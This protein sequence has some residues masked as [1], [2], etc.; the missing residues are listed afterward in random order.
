ME[1]AAAAAEERWE[2]QAPLRVG[3]AESV[4][5]LGDG[6]AKGPRYEIRVL[7]VAEKA[8]C[9][10]FIVPQGRE[11]EYI[12]GTD[13]GLAQVAASAGCGRL[14]AVSL[15][16]RTGHRFG[17]L[18]AVQGELEGIVVDL[19]PKGISGKIPFVTVGG[20]LGGREVVAR[21]VT[22]SGDTYFVEEVDE[23]AA[24]CRRLVFGSNERVVQTEVALLPAGSCKKKGRGK[25]K[26]G[27]AAKRAAAADAPPRGGG[28]R[29]DPDD[30][31][32]AY[33]AAMLAAC[34][35]ADAAGDFLLVGLG[36]GA[37][38]S[39]V[40]RYRPAARLTVR[41]LDEAVVDVATTWFGFRHGADDPRTNVLVGDDLDV[42]DA[43]DAAATFDVVAVDV[44]AKDASLGMCC[45]PKAFV[46]TDYVSKVKAK[47]NDGGAFVVNV[48]ARR[49]EDY[50]ETCAN[51]RAVF[52]AVSVIRPTLDDVNRV[53]VARK[54]TEAPAAARARAKK[55]LAGWLLEANKPDDPHD[56]L[57]MIAKLALA[58]ERAEGS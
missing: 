53:L 51:V 54:T 33:H 45:P 38:A 13:D 16:S 3:R 49:H 46:S 29:V 40:R 4:R 56:L 52:G 48:V 39:A 14:L 22:A 32:S 23:G 2:K 35:T 10:C 50:A 26:A 42:F 28:R 37:L 8:S 5:V 41:E 34:G 58:D 36:G 27:G 19:A 43:L 24:R 15:L 12:F 7:D 47:L 1:F 18:K 21:G 44:D 11:H 17:D 30:L 20:D 55:A 9:S 57:D 6:D 31:R 25:K